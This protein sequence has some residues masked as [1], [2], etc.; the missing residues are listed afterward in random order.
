[1]L[2]RRSLL[3]AVPGA[4]CT[5]RVASQAPAQ[6]AVL[7]DDGLYRQSWFLESFLELGPDLA[8]AAAKGKRLA[9]LWELRGCPYCKQMHLVNFAQPAISDFVRERFE[10][11]QLNLIGAREV[12]D[13][14]GEKLPEKRLAEKY[15]VRFTPTL[16]FF[17]NVAPDLGAR[18]PRERE[19]AR[20]QGYLPPKEFRALFTFVVEKAYERGSLVSYLNSQG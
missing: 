3:A 12:T 11:L 14:D 8:E 15:G 2:T 1:M 9:V 7:T 20:W 17:R 18:K 19:V 4:L 5:T 10:I 16:Q 6:E 13:F